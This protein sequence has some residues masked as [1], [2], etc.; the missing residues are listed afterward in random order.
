MILG[1]R[2]NRLIRALCAGFALLGGAVLSLAALMTVISVVGRN[3][4]FAGLDS[5]PGDTELVAWACAFAL[6]CFAP[7][8]LIQR[9]NITVDLFAGLMSPQT[10]RLSTLVGLV[11]LLAMACLILWRL[12]AGMN[13]KYDPY[14]MET[15]FILQLPV[16]V[17]YAL[18]LP[19][20]GLLI[21]AALVAV[22]EELAALLGGSPIAA[23]EDV[24]A[25]GEPRDE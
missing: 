3:L 8:C 19:G 24:A 5:I 6:F 18:C 4:I 21:L 16:W 25:F 9:G 15:T 10:H 12:V 22:G 17:G 13:D 1:R 2:L 7:W 23:D 14:F 20:A 11:C